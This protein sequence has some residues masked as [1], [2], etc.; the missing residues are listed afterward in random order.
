MGIKSKSKEK[1]ETK[2]KGKPEKEKPETKRDAWT[3]RDIYTNVD[4][5]LKWKKYCRIEWKDE[6]D[7]D[8]SYPFYELSLCKSCRTILYNYLSNLKDVEIEVEK[9]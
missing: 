2:S 9:I 3:T 4:G 7:E 8:G 5:K 6:Q 1:P